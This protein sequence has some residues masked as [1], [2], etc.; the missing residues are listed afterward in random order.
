M[1]IN[2]ILSELR[3]LADSNREQGD[4]FERVIANYLRESPLYRD[5]IA[6]VWQWSEW[7]RRKRIDQTDVGI[8][9][10]IHTHENEYWAVQCKCYAEDHYLQKTDIDSF[11]STAGQSWGGVRF[12]LCLI[13]A[14]TPRWSKHA[15][16]ALE[17]R[18]P[19]CIRLGL[20]D[21]AADEGVNWLTLLPG[22]RQRIE[23]PAKRNLKPHQ[24]QA[25]DEVCAGFQ[26]SDRGQLIMAC[27]TGKTFTALKIAEKQIGN[28]GRVLFLV[29]SL[30]LLSQTLREWS[31]HHEWE[32]MRSF[33]VCSDSK[34]GRDN[35][36]I[37]AYDL[38]IP[39][40]T[41]GKQLV[42]GL[43]LPLPEGQKRAVQ[44]VFATYHSIGVV[45]TAQQSGAEKFD[46]VICDEAHRTTGVELQ[47][48]DASYY[49]RVHDDNYLRAGKRL[50]MTATPRIYS[51]TARQRAREKDVEVFSMDDP[52]KYGVEFHR[53]DFSAAVTKDLLS[54]YKVLVLA[55]NEEYASRAVQGLLATNGEVNLDD[56]AKIIGCWNGLSKRIDE[57]EAA[58]IT[59]LKPMRRAVAFTQS[60]KASKQV[61]GH[62][63]AIV[64][65]Y[66]QANPDDIAAL[67][68]ETKHVDGTQNALIRNQALQWLQ[69]EPEDNSCHILSNV[70]CL[71]EGVDVPALDAVMF[72]N[73]RRSQVDVV[74]SVGRVMRKAE[75]KDYG[76]IILPICVGADSAPEEALNKNEKYQVVWSVLQAL[77]AHDNRFNAE[78]NRIDLN[79]QPSKQINVIGVGFGSGPEQNMVDDVEARPYLHSQ[80]SIPLALEEW[81]NAL[82]ARVVLKCGDRRYWENWAKDVADIAGRNITRINTLVAGSEAGYRELF[83]EFMVEL[84]QNLNPAVTED[85][86]IEMLAQ[87]LITRPVFDALFENYSFIGNN[88]VSKTMQAMLELLDEKNLETEAASLEGFYES[89][90]Q[91]ASGIDNAEG[92]QKV[93]I[94]LYEKFFKTA[95]PKMAESLGIVYTPVEVVDFILDSTDALL[96][97]EFGKGLTAENVHILDP[98]TGTGTFMTRL[99]RSQYLIGDEDLERKY[100]K[101]LHANEIVL[102][103]YYIAAVNIEETYHDRLAGKRRQMRQDDTV[104]YEPFE[105]IVLTDTFQIN[106]RDG[107]MLEQIFPVNSK[108]V[109][110]QKDTPIRVVMGNPPY[111]AGQ[112]SGNDNNANLRYSKL[113]E[114]IAGSYA[115]HSRATLKNSLYDSYI[116]AFRWAA[117]RIGDE[118]IVAYVTNGGWLDGNAMDGFRRCLADE[119]SSIY[120]FNLRGNA[121]TSGEQRRREKDSVF[122][123]GTRTAISILIL[124]KNPLHKDECRIYYHDIG[125]YLNRKQKLETIKELGNVRQM[126][127]RT[128]IPNAYYD[129]INQRDEA[130]LNYLPLGDKDSKRNKG[131]VPTVFTLYSSGVKTNRDAWAYNFSK[132][133]L[134]RNMRSTIVFYN[135]EVNRYRRA[136][137]GKH[138]EDKPEAQDFINYDSTR[139]HWD[140]ANKNDLA[141]NITSNLNSDHIRHGMYRP[142]CKQWLYFDKQWNNRRYQQPSIFPKSDPPNLAI[143][144]S[145]IGASKNFSA[146]MVNRVPDIQLMFNG[147]CFPRY[148]FTSAQAQGRQASLVLGEMEYQRLD[149]IP[150]GS[151]SQF[152]SHYRNK[153]IDADSI[154][155]YVYGILH[156]P[157][158]KTRYSADLKKMLPRIPYVNSITDFKSI[159]EAGRQLAELHVGYEDVEPWPLIIREDGAGVDVKDRFPVR[160]MRFGGSARQPDKSLIHYNP[161][162]TI[163]GIPLTA[164]DYVVN[165]KSAL[166]WV[167][168]R[169]QATTHK[170]SGITNDPNDWSDD[171]RYILDLLQK[172]VRVSI[173][174]VEIVN[175]LPV[176]DQIAGSTLKE[177]KTEA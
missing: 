84:R 59:D 50:Y 76:Y 57:A 163:E 161:H 122:G 173:D 153:E 115:L 56:A 74:Q 111:S 60:I 165:G 167:M 156:S 143:C 47:G 43:E 125:D 35:E 42:K 93:I 88:P 5:R 99:L 14:T 16:E 41:D 128:I 20:T 78:I 38:V 118:G 91:R 162:V 62:F 39:P 104:D 55:I 139:I 21:L 113:D 17:R 27:G 29:P 155:Y 100:R 134:V 170:D 89:V 30:A 36:D 120:C 83:E 61:A 10:V 80:M 49:T 166:E 108:R 45:H 96:K 101:E 149:N 4:L 75:G 168:E 66:R 110:R 69:D 130:F 1:G 73:P 6:E 34:V 102:L 105:G 67:E 154:F 51:E 107:D 8:D 177:S 140:V 15:E 13:I 68:C 144:V 151:V 44:V 46:L 32:F 116:R 159:S 2:E 22:V 129:W 72:L 64:E 148:R 65:E 121:R 145:G 150:A 94:E 79:K 12:S 3:Q 169:Y 127:W 95:F 18:Q 40:T 109:L 160:K 52:A 135:E 77:R 152:Q 172:V 98:F 117:D 63:S 136:C 137:E 157:A 141:K 9:L 92:R 106:E 119:F 90:R 71:S 19:P 81:K 53:L 124:V 164:Y 82:L 54:D 87:H 33:A 86:A 132:D 24:I 175:S 123:Q 147:Q 176:L 23:K 103:A 171:P 25:V 114:S 70:R 146:L 11:L 142:Y 138:D 131:T 31:A 48:E 28:G 133:S 37:S 112:R 26:K 174:T 7:A 85:D 158:Y 97:Q 58:G 126:D